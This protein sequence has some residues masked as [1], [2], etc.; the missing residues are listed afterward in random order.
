MMLNFSAADDALIELLH[1]PF[2][3]SNSNFFFF[4]FLTFRFIQCRER[5]KAAGTLDDYKLRN[6]NYIV[7][8][9]K[10]K[11]QKNLRI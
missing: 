4:F 10:L 7:G 3:Y 8:L 11:K 5:L 1:I 9:F 2:W 6:A